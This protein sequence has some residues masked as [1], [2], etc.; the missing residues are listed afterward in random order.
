MLKKIKMALKELGTHHLIER[1]YLKLSLHIYPIGRLPQY[2]A[3]SSVSTS[4]T[5]IRGNGKFQTLT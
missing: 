4:H 2:Q 1:K 3:K 5:S